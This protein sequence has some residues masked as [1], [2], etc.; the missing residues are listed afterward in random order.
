M[1]VIDGSSGSLSRNFRQARSFNTNSRKFQQLWE[2]Y[3]NLEYELWANNNLQHHF[4]VV[5]WSIGIGLLTPKSHRFAD[6]VQTVR[7]ALGEESQ[8]EQICKSSNN[9]AGHKDLS[10]GLATPLRSSYVLVV[11][12]T[13]KVG[14]SLTSL[15]L[16][17]QPQ[18]SLEFSTKK[19][20]VIQTAQGFSTGWKLLGDA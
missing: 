11:E 15:P 8:Q 20:R 19:S 1:S 13:T 6:W 5:R 3:Y 10:R 16:S 17:K 12:V 7:E 18:R 9:H 2:N 4:L 14:V